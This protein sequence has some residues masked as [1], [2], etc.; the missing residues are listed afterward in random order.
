MPNEFVLVPSG[1]DPVRLLLDR[2][3][4][5]RSH[6]DLE[7]L[8]LPYVVFG[9]FAQYLLSLTEAN[10]DF[11]CAVAFLNELAESGDRDLENLV[12]VSV[13]ESLAGDFRSARVVCG[14]REEARKLFLA[15][16]NPPGRKRC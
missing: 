9:F 14:L 2:I 11:D 6:L 12:Q 7:D 5:F 3:P 13:F 10:P 15:V 8:E 4:S 16:D 1:S